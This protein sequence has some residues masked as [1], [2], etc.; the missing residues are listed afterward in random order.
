MDVEAAKLLVLPSPGDGKGVRRKLAL[1]S[2]NHGCGDRGGERQCRSG[3]QDGMEEGAVE[4]RWWCKEKKE[5]GA[6]GRKQLPMG[7]GR[8][9]CRL[10]R[11]KKTT[12]RDGT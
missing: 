2:V 7:I 12:G 9:V 6:R 5:K 11:E 10:T 1:R 3:V 4:I 8:W